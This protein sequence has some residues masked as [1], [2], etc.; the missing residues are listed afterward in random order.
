MDGDD[1]TEPDI[2]PKLDAM[3][4]QELAVPR[5]SE[6]RTMNGLAVRLNTGVPRV[7]KPV[8]PETG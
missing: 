4:R 1:L 3:L 6:E 7:Q 5:A 2:D 8:R